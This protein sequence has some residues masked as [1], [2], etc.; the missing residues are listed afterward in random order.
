M[1][2]ILLALAVVA[3]AQPA[4]QTFGG[5]YLF[6]VDDGTKASAVIQSA[7]SYTTEELSDGV[8]VATCQALDTTNAP[9]PG[10]VSVSF[11]LAGGQIVVPGDPGAPTPP[12]PPADNTYPAPVGLTA[13]VVTS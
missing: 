1:S 9:M 4:D 5:S 7:P 12:P 10:G 8:Y 2:K 13:T 3:T 11:T 6:K